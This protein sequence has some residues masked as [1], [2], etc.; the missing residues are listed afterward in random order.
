MAD[1]SP[2]RSTAAHVIVEPEVLRAPT[3]IV[4]DE[5][6]EHHLRRVVR[7]RDGATVGVTDGEGAWCLGTALV[8]GGSLGIEPASTVAVEK[9]PVPIRIA[10]AMPKGDRL[11]WLVQKV[12]E[13]GADRLT[14]LHADRSV[15]RWKSDK[16]EQQRA[17][18]ARIADEACRQSRRVWR[19]QIDGPVDARAVLGDFVLAEPGGRA[20][21]LG[22]RSIAVGPEGGW[23][24]EE[25]TQG[26]DTV[27]LGGNVLRTETA[28]VAATALCVAFNR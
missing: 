27:A 23:T 15:V 20:L 5:A 19:L 1:L 28:A 8:E 24:A 25:L 18:L 12:T 4:L 21:A 13:L 16:V 26:A 6:T 3:L 11:D 7:L 17:R 9:R 14:L 22:D 2:L 10:A